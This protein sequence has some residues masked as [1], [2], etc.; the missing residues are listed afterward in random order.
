MRAPFRPVLQPVGWGARPLMEG[1]WDEKPLE[2]ELL[3]E[4]PLDPPPIRPPLPI[5]H[6]RL[7][8]NIGSPERPG[9]NALAISVIFLFPVGIVLLNIIVLIQKVQSTSEILDSL[10]IGN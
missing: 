5:N 9:I 3:P 7:Y 2:K 10:L 6:L 1:L 8:P 4:K